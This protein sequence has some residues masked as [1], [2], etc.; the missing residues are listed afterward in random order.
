MS[1]IAIVES[2]KKN[3][4]KIIGYAW[5]ICFL[6]G[7][8]YYAY[9]PD[10]LY[11]DKTGRVIVSPYNGKFIMK[12]CNSDGSI[13]TYIEDM[14]VGELKSIDKDYFYRD[15]IRAKCNLNNI[16]NR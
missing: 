6:I 14:P 13:S 9:V 5:V 12:K 11:Q 10:G 2:T 4:I 16:I 3:S 8:N 7:N 1:N 15:F